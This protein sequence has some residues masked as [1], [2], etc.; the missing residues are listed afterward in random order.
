MTDIRKQVCGTVVGTRKDSYRVNHQAGTELQQ[1][2]NRA[3]GHELELDQVEESSESLQQNKL[4]RVSQTLKND[5]FST[6]KTTE[7][8]RFQVCLTCSNSA[9]K[10][11]APSKPTNV[12][13]PT[14]DPKKA[15]R[16]CQSG[17]KDE[18]SLKPSIPHS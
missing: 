8:Q 2:G 14:I 18:Q 17:Y 3:F 11:P 6:M 4:F 7:G 13:S 15:T 9:R 10:T 12:A 5:A 16:S 1:F